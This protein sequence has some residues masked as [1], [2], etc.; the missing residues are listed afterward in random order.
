MN[1]KGYQ[2]TIIIKYDDNYQCSWHSNNT[3]HRL[4]DFRW[5]IMTIK[6]KKYNNYKKER[7]I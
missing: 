4:D 3:T 5:I 2:N 7:H 6:I 1:S